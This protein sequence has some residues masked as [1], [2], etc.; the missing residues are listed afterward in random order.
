VLLLGGGPAGARDPASLGELAIPVDRVPDWYPAPEGGVPDTSGW[1][2]VDVT[3]A[4]YNADPADNANSDEAA[5]Q[6]AIDDAAPRTIIFLPAGTYNFSGNQQGLLL[7]KSEIVLR[8][9]GMH[10]TTLSFDTLGPDD[11]PEYENNGDGCAGQGYLLLIGAGGLGATG[12]TGGTAR[13][14]TELTL[15]DVSFLAPGDW[16]L[17]DQDNDP[18]KVNNC[19]GGV[20]D[21]NGTKANS[22]VVRVQDVNVAASTITIDR[23]LR[24]DF[25]YGGQTVTKMA[26]IESVGVEDLRLLFPTPAEEDDAY[27]PPMTLTCAANSWVDGVMIDHAYNLNIQVARSARNLF[28]RSLFDYLKTADDDPAT[29]WNRYS[30]VQFKAGASDNVFQNSVMVNMNVGP[31]ISGGANGNVTAYNYI[32]KGTVGCQRGLFLHVRQPL[33][34]QRLRLPRRL[35][36]LLGLA[37]PANDLLPQPA[38]GPGHAVL[39]AAP[40]Q[41]GLHLHHLPERRGEHRAGLHGRRWLLL[42]G[43]ELLLVRRRSGRGAFRAPVDGAECLPR[44]EERQRLRR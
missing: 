16:V 21:C 5:I 41:P 7:E 1:T 13:G 10:Q 36:Q 18:A 3:Q 32:R 6:T 24:D 42:S 9:A 39:P 25:D 22:Y 40:G 26:P 19:P 38:G 33:R 29:Q 17:A 4:P 30:G 34:G 14:T 35:R 2:V 23:P 15:A 28:Q 12:W 37:G 31:M 8:G 20:P 43:G 44:H 27:L 11:H